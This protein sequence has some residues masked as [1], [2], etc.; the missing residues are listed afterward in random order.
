MRLMLGSVGSRGLLV[1]LLAGALG[2]GCATESPP[3]SQTAAPKP[4]PEKKV[5]IGR[6]LPH[7]GCRALGPIKGV[8]GGGGWSQT[9]AKEHDAYSP[10]TAA[11]RRLGGDYALIDAVA[12]DDRGVTIT[13]LAY[14]CFD[15]PSAPPPVVTAA[16]PPSAPKVVQVGRQLPHTACRPLGIIMGS[17]G[18]WNWTKTETKM[19]HAY[20]QL[21]ESTRT[22]GGD[23][24]LIDVVGTDD[25]GLT[26]SG[27]A[28]DCS[29]PPPAEAE[30]P[31][32]VVPAS[33]SAKPAAS[34]EERLRRL[35]ELMKAKGLIT[36]EEYSTRRRV[37]VDGL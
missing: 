11:A 9:D 5:Q 28:Y 34:V 23:Y 21:M 6:R 33:E 16:P 12:R 3:A 2:A 30:A 7:P 10:L 13:G 22:L 27:N 4:R 8:G 29:R 15:R 35:E 18:G 32:V 36:P 24:A 14:D 20:E 25:R 19:Q 31:V 37:I 17:G 26:I 1:G